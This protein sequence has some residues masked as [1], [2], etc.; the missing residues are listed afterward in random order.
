M[1]NL[2]WFCLNANVFQWQLP[3]D[4]PNLWVGVLWPLLYPAIAKPHCPHHQYLLALFARILKD[5]LGLICF[6]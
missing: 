2:L 1:Y 5:A 6:H 4:S 3:T